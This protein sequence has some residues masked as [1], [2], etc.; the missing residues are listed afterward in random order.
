MLMMHYKSFTYLKTIDAQKTQLEEMNVKLERKVNE[1]LS[2]ILRSDRLKKYLPAQLVDSIISSDLEKP[3]STE[4]VKITIFFSDI[5]D[6]TLTT[7]SMESEELLKLLNS[8]LAEMTEIALRWGGTIDKFIGD[9]IMIFFGAPVFNDDRT[10]ALNCVKM[11]I[12][13]QKKM[14]DLQSRWFDTGFEKPLSIRIG[15]NTGV[16]TVG[17][18]GAPDRLS[19]TAIGG[20]VNIASRLEQECPPNSILISHPTYVLVKDEITCSEARTLTVKGIQRE[21]LAYEVLYG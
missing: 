9:A 3:I 18:F 12:E 15:I 6:F 10:H 4:R 20:Q 2:V 17:N 19:Y 13:M 1:Q 7:D 11:A 8:Y 21:L 5:K 14:K 16:A